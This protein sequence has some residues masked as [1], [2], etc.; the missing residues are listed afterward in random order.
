MPITHATT[1]GPIGE[2]QWNETHDVDDAALRTA[3][4]VA[5]GATA[6]ATDAALRD[7]ATHT[8]SQAISTITGLQG[9]LD[10]KLTAAS[11]DTLAKLNA[12]ITDAT[13]L[14]SSAVATV[15]TT[16][17]YSDLSGKPMIIDWTTDQGA[18]N[19]HAGNIPDLSATY[20]AVGHNHSGVYEPA[21]ATILKDAD[22]GTSVQAHDADTAKLD[23]AQAW[24]ALQTFTAGMAGGTTTVA[25][26]GATQTVALDGKVHV[27]TLTANCTI[28]AS[29][30]GSA[31]SAALIVT[32][33][34]ATGG[35]TLTWPAG[36]KQLDTQSL[37][38]T[39][40]KDSAWI[41]WTPD[42]GTTYYL[43]GAGA[44]A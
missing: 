43:N 41:L 27:I 12:L 42:G 19:L 35:R 7:R 17:A 18:T 31:Y 5:D 39:A 32:R 23:V 38:T 20:S 10:D 13:L 16:G 14:A 40:S 26:S 44:E 37:N 2:T 33:Q 21:D 1:T 8:G 3:L 9:S 4:N 11:V 25:A 6:N 29:A 15:A 24:S 36:V 30:T 28:T 34:D 22:I